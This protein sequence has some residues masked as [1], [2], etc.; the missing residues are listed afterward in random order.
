MFSHVLEQVAYGVAVVTGDSLDGS[1]PIFF[2]KQ[3][4]YFGDFFFR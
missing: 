2:Y 1:D 4:G 3:F